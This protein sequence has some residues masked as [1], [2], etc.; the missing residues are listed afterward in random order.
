MVFVERDGGFIPFVEITAREKF[1][2][3]A[4]AF[5][6]YQVQPSF[7]LG[8]QNEAPGQ[9]EA[10]CLGA[11][12]VAGSEPI[13]RV[14]VTDVTGAEHEIPVVDGWVAFAGTVTNSADDPVS[15]GELQLTVYGADDAV[16]A[17]YGEGF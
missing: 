14:V 13:D 15:P 3:E 7:G 17:E 9:W 2:D 10:D 16:L 6:N 1:Q 12:F 11:A 5:G 4:D 8:C